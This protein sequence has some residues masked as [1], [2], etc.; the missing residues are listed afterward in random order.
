MSRLAPQPDYAAPVVQEFIE[1]VRDH[2]ID[3]TNGPSAM[4]NRPF[5]P[6]PSLQAY[7]KAHNRMSKLLRAMYS[8]RDYHHAVTHLENWYTI[9]FSI[10]ILIGKGNYIMEFSQHTN[11]R[12]HHLPFLGKPLHFPTDPDDPTF[13]SKFCEEQFA[14]CAHTLEYNDIHTKL[15]DSCIL[16]IVSKEELARGGSAAI[17]KI[18]LHPYYDKLNSAA[19]DPM[20]SLPRSTCIL[21]D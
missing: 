5:M 7:L 4:P 12:D 18:L 3:G 1:W 17:Y 2:C 13:W 9:V 16:P 11:L 19:D 15:E 6:F 8:E 10:L 21:S 20:V 14:F